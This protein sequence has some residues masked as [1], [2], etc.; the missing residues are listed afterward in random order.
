MK[1]CK[2]CEIKISQGSKLGQIDHII[3]CKTFDMSDPEQQR[4][5]FHYT[6]LQP[7]WQY[8]NLSKGYTLDSLKVSLTNQGY[9]RI[10]IEKA[11]ELANKQLARAAPVMI[12]K[13]QII[14]RS[15]PET[16]IEE[17]QGFFKRLSRLFK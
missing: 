5:C 6:N 13:P 17:K 16:I 4:K 15:Y 11:I 7:L 1:K 2:I 10:S 9:S 8:E 3:P 12:E 14:Y